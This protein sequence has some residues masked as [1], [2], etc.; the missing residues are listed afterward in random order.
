V[1]S[2]EPWKPSRIVSGG[3]T[4]VDRAALDWAIE[5]GI[6]HG[7]WCPAGRRSEDGPIAVH[8]N[9]Q[10][11]PTSSYLERTRRNVQCSDVT[12]VFNCG[13]LDGGT[14]QTVRL[15]SKFERPCLVVALDRDTAEARAKAIRS[16]LASIRPAVLNV[17]GPRE[18][19]RPGI[20]AHARRLLDAV[21]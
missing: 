14:A 20:G 16:W 8:Y 13:V 5:R 2:T 1:H 19:K 17:A 18:T 9:L 10:E 3:Q 15:A 6:E 11:T 12:L 7:G 4:G 21:M